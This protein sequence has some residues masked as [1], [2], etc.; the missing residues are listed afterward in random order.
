MSLTIVA[1]GIQSLSETRHVLPPRGSHR[2]AAAPAN[3]QR[4]RFLFLVR[5]FVDQ[6]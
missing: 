1:S 2:G 5:S 3:H 4:E 6:A